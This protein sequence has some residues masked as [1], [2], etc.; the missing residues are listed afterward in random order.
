[1][2]FK[3]SQVESF[4]LSLKVSCMERDEVAILMSRSVRLTSH[5]IIIKLFVS[6]NLSCLVLS[7][8]LHPKELGQ[9]LFFLPRLSKKNSPFTGSQRLYRHCW[10]CLNNLSVSSLSPSLPSPSHPLLSPYALA[11][12]C[13]NVVFLASPSLKFSHVDLSYLDLFN[14]DCIGWGSFAQKKFV[15]QWSNWLKY[16]TYS[17][18]FSSFFH[19]LFERISD[20]HLPRVTILLGIESFKHSLCFVVDMGMSTGW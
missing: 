14:H 9:Y 12:V 19:D 18:S 16:K 4:D 3:T 13:W 8:V 11:L 15:G 10:F 7:V 6:W 17:S 2:S 1:M 5:M 20:Y